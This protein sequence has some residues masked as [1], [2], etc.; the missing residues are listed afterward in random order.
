MQYDLCGGNK[1]IQVYLQA[2]TGERAGFSMDPDWVPDCDDDP[3]EV[4][5]AVLNI[6]ETKYLYCGGKDRVE[7]ALRA[8]EACQE[9]SE[10]NARVNRLHELRRR[11]VCDAA[12][13]NDLLEDETET[14]E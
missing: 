6:C 9:L 13:Y 4:A 3:I 8:M 5:R 10:K 7:N 11:I 12:E 1:Q 2:A 14:S